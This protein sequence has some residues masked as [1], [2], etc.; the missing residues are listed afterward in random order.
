MAR[1]LGRGLCSELWLRPSNW[2][3]YLG[4]TGRGASCVGDIEASQAQEC[5]DLRTGAAAAAL[6]HSALAGQF[7][8]AL[9]RAWRR[10]AGVAH[11]C[12]G[13]RHLISAEDTRR[14]PHV[15]SS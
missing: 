3:C 1:M 4:E 6:N 5:I 9:A 11:M 8:I 13:P 14:W 12:A 2:P 7:Q 10:H 15:A